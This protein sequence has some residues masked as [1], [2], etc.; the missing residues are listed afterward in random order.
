MVSSEIGELELF[1]DNINSTKNYRAVIMGHT[2]KAD[3]Q[4]KM[5]NSHFAYINTGTWKASTAPTY[6]QV[7]QA[8]QGLF[9]ALLEWHKNADGPYFTKEVHRKNVG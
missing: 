4:K 2:H 7:E 5:F 3:F 6:T 9:V 8:D 1:A